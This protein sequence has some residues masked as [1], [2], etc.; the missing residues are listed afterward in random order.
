ML[1]TDNEDD[2]MVNYLR[3][4]MNDIQ[5]TGPNKRP[6]K[7]EGSWKLNGKHFKPNFS[8]TMHPFQIVF[9]NFR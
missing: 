9:L 8:N 3:D 7:F 5:N 1:A 4:Y 2:E 6:W